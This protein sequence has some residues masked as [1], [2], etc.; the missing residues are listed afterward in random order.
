MYYKVPGGEKAVFT[1]RIKNQYGSD[2]LTASP[3][4]KRKW[5]NA[6]KILRK[7]GFPPK[8]LYQDKLSIW[9]EGGIKTRSDIQ[10]FKDF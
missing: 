2:F 9:D 6:F 1:H 4:T 8:I 3:Q 5:S 10:H 7:K